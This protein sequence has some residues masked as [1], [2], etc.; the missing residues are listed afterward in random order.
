MKETKK[1]IEK[2]QI[3]ID[4]LLQKEHLN[5][6]EFAERINVTQ[7]A[8][9]NWIQN[10]N[11]MD[12]SIKERIKRMFGGEQGKYPEWLITKHFKDYSYQE[13]EEEI[14]Q[15]AALVP[16]DGKY[17]SAIRKHL[18]ESIWV[19]IALTYI[20]S[21]EFDWAD[22]TNGI[23]IL[24]CMKDYSEYSSFYHN[25]DCSLLDARKCLKLLKPF[26]IIPQDQK[27]ESILCRADECN[28]ALQC[29]FI[30]EECDYSD[31]LGIAGIAYIKAMHNLEFML[32]YY[33]DVRPYLEKYGTDKKYKQH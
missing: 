28:R 18:E 11:G 27:M 17:E 25:V 12:E 1:L 22:L 16:I 30:D 10:K 29:V 2:K 19:V 14:P 20:N 6:K 7:Q 21:G 13:L 5:Q 31:E 32:E 15:L 33:T 23:G 8:V 4:Y 9:S 24:A 26:N 3:D